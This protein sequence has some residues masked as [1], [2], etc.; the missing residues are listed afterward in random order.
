MSMFHYHRF[1]AQN[2]KRPRKF[3]AILQASIEVSF[4]VFLFY[5]NLLMGEFNASNG[6]GETLSFALN[7]IFTGA[8]LLIAIV[9]ALVGYFLFESLRKRGPRLCRFCLRLTMK[10]ACLDSPSIHQ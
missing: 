9:S 2:P 6:R 8:N 4:V 10:P 5:S 7:Y 3:S 1:M